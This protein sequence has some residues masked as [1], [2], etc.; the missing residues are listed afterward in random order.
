MSKNIQGTRLVY[1]L[2]EYA[3]KFIIVSC[4]VNEGIYIDNVTYTGSFDETVLL[5]FLEGISPVEVLF[6]SEKNYFPIA[7]GL[8]DRYDVR[9]MHKNMGTDARVSAFLDFIKNNVMFR[10]DYDEIPQYNEFMDGILDYNGSDDCAAIYSVASLA[11]YV[12]KKYNI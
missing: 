11:Y 4:Y 12:S 7:R 5:S 6:E 2:P 9:I 10:A 8:R 3:G 1:V